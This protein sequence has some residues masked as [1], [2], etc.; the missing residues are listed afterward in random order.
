[1]ASWLG[2]DA[3]VVLGGLGIV[4][5]LTSILY[6]H[7]QTQAARRQADHAVH[8]TKM[9]AVQ[10]LFDRMHSLRDRLGRSPRALADQ[11][12]ANPGLKAAVEEAG[13]FEDYI[14]YREAMEMFQQAY[15]L[16]R[17]GVLDDENW[18]DFTGNF[19]VWSRNPTF[20]KTL[21]FAPNY[22]YLHEEFARFFEDIFTGK[23]ISD[24][25]G[26]GAGA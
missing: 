10:Q 20:R 3:G 5:G 26:R 17:D 1:M 24:P 22:G 16:R 2:L 11:L 8:M 14:L 6:A 4:T 19:V 25:V 12:D 23:P 9:E 13:A 18:R 7:F 15:I 21:R